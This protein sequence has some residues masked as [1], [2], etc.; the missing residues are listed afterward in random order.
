LK[1]K[2]IDEMSRQI[3]ELTITLDKEIEKTLPWFSRA[4]KS[5]YDKE[6][7]KQYYFNKVRGEE[8]GI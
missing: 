8:N 7:V 3:A 6:F 5:E 4:D 1:D 2:V